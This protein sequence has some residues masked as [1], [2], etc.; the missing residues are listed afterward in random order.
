MKA[1]HKI[2]SR[3][4]CPLRLLDSLPKSDCYKTRVLFECQEF[5]GLIVKGEDARWANRI[6]FEIWEFKKVSVLENS[7]IWLRLAGKL[8]MSTSSDAGAR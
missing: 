7:L 5:R 2:E 8:P 6:H 4:I 1:P 3:L